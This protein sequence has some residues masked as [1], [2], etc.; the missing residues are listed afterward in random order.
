MPAPEGS[1]EV[2]YYVGATTQAQVGLHSIASVKSFKLTGVSF[3][4]FL[5]MSAPQRKQLALN[6][7]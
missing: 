5:A 4:E 7:L 6:A 3:D 2:Y 1:A